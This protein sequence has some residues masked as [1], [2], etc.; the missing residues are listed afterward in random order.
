MMSSISPADSKQ[1]RNIHRNDWINRLVLKEDTYTAL[2]HAEAHCPR[3]AIKQWEWEKDRNDQWFGYLSRARVYRM[4]NTHRWRF[5]RAMRT[6]ADWIEI[7]RNFFVGNLPFY[8]SAAVS[9]LS[10]TFHSTIVILTSALAF[11][12]HWPRKRWTWRGRFFFLHFVNKIK[13]QKVNYNRLGRTSEPEKKFFVF[14]CCHDDC[15]CYCCRW[16]D[17]VRQFIHTFPVDR[18]AQRVTLLRQ[19]GI[20]K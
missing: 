8:I 1:N 9:A 18:K 16:M 15:C 12:S 11:T 10:R 3:V 17:R 4:P 6:T 2:T 5:V 19:N 14:V 20:V 7:K 13:C